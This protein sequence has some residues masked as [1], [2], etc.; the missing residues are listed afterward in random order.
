MHK[1]R[2][3]ITTVSF[4]FLF[5]SAGAQQQSPYA[6][7]WKGLMKDSITTFNY[8]I[9]ITKIENG[10]VWGTGMSGNQTLYCETSLRG[11]IKNGRLSIRETEVVRTNYRNKD[12]VCLLELDVVEVKN[13]MLLGVYKPITNAASCLPGSFTLSF[14][15][16]V[17]ALPKVEVVAPAPKPT[18]PQKPRE[19]TLIKEIVIDA[20]SAFVQLYDNGIVDG[21]MI[22]LTDNDAVVFSNA[23][24]STQALKHTIS[25]KTTNTHSISFVADNLGS[26]PPNTGLMVITANRQRWEIN[27][28]SDFA[29]TSYVKVILR[30]RK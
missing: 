23:A 3:F 26:I 28:S 4:S 14:Q 8:S 11:T 15:E 12:A 6:G 16:P 1:L 2:L 21:D 22:T 7:E 5:L 29:K 27:F 10:E 30:P 17:D 20:D 18:P 13:K 25:N 9:R 24:L 19:L